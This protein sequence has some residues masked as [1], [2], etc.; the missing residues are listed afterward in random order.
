MGA[1]L[2]SLLLVTALV[3]A[4]PCEGKP[5][6]HVLSVR[7]ERLG[8]GF[9]LVRREVCNDPTFWEAIGHF[10]FLFFKSREL[11]QV[12]QRSIS[13]SGRYALFES[14]GKLL[15]FDAQDK[16]VCDVTDGEFALPELI[17]WYEKRQVVT[18]TYYDSHS[19]STIG[20]AK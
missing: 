15:L 18:V 4:D 12:G 16:S 13:P 11:G 17:T 6:G 20:L 9:K 2:L 19:P 3:G 5:V 7:S 1:L 14:A 8:H 10:D